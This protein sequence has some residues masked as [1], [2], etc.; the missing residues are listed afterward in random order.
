M[1]IG[2]SQ[3][4]SFIRGSIFYGFNEDEGGGGN[5][6]GVMTSTMTKDQMGRIVVDGAWPQID[7]RMMWMN[8]RWAQPN[9]IPNLYMGG[10]EAPVWWAEFPDKSRGLP[11]TDCSTAAP[12]PNMSADP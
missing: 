1:D 5:A 8:E 4:G 11:P 12:E 6:Q 10:D 7:G 9:V 3:S 2:S